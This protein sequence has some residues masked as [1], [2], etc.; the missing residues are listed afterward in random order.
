MVIR[1]ADLKNFQNL[2]AP[3]N[4]IIRLYYLL[5]LAFLALTGAQ[6]QFAAPL[7]VAGNPYQVS[8]IFHVGGE[9]SWDFLTVDAPNHLLFVPRFTHTM[10]LDA[11]TG[12]LVG[13]IPGQKRGL[14]VAIVPRVGRGFITDGD[15]GTVVVFDLRTYKVLGKVKVVD[16]ADGISY[17]PAS[18]KVLV[19]CEDGGVVF[20]FSPSIDLKSG[21]ATE[22]DVGGRP[23][24][25][26]SDEQG[27]AYIGL[28]DKDQVAVVDTKTMKLLNRWS[29]APGG[30]P[31][32]LGMYR[33]HRRLFVGCRNPAR[34]VVMSAD[35]GKVLAD[36]P[37][38]PNNDGVIF[39][40]GGAFASCGGDATIC[41]A[42]ETSP[43][44]Y[45]IVQVIKTK[46]G[47]RT[48]GLD[49]LTHTFYLPTE[50]FTTPATS[51]AEPIPKPDSFMIVVVS[52]K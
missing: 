44:K 13:D 36:L 19:G 39:D 48:M 40:S 29:T 52:R 43:G 9:G 15:D 16:D 3:M 49:S 33:E 45:E 8:Q 37:I 38:G 42:H 32:G 24:H 11:A 28:K 47:A 21:K 10:V 17:D 30:E 6:V 20:G 31:V 18:D 1:W 12:K 50:E 2:S 34:L 14:G 35:D 26:V 5:S 22:L 7:P 25:I 27:K 41:V 4:K 23:E 46:L 51:K